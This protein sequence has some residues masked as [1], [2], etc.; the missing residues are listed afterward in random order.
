[1]S[2]KIEAVIVCKNYSDFLQI[3]L[4]I[5]KIHFDNI[6][7]V[8][9]KD[10]EATKTLCKNFNVNYLIYNDFNKNGAKFNFGGARSFGLQNLKYN[11][12]VIFLDGD[13]IMPENFRE[14]FDINARDINK[15]YGSYRRFIPSYKDYKDLTNNI[16]SKDDFESIE[17]SGCGFWQCVNLNSSLIKNYDKK[18]LYR[19]SYSAE[20]VDIDFMRL[21]CPLIGDDTNLVRTNIELLHLGSSDG[22]HHHGRNLIDSFFDNTYNN[23][24]EKT[25][26]QIKIIQQKIKYRNIDLTFFYPEN[27]STAVGSA[28]GLLNEEYTKN[29]NNINFEPND[30]VVDL[31]CNVGIVSMIIAKLFPSVKIYAF[32]PSPLAILCLKLGCISNGILNIQPFE[33]AVGTENKKNV[34]FYSTDQDIS[35][36]IEEKSMD[37]S[38]TKTK[39]SLLN[40][41]SIDE[42]FTNPLLNIDKIKYMKVDIEA[43]EFELFDYLFTQKP[44]FLDRIEYLNVEVHP[45]DGNPKSEKLKKDL[46]EKFNDRVFF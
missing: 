16:K 21:W 37:P 44:E 46:K 22:R 20:Q 41:I 14:L 24:M 42:L 27:D 31:G 29:L 33:F 43:K 23:D 1:M 26:S 39:F 40:L 17:G 38:D 18:S 45:F 2:R 5:N 32:D 13:I 3:T 12:W 7:V 30:I 10:D 25:P 35:C 15:F 36:L 11:D 9:S 34:K 28:H 8:T 6:I 19:D 4:P